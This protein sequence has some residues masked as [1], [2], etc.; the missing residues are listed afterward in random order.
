MIELILLKEENNELNAVYKFT[1]EW[2]I[3][4]KRFYKLLLHRFT[5]HTLHTEIPVLHT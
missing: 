2:E 1:N 4:N 5:V 3:K